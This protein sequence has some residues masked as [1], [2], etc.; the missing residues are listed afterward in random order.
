MSLAVPSK[1]ALPGP[2]RRPKDL[3]ADMLRN[4]QRNT[5]FVGLGLVRLTKILIAAALA[6][7]FA[8]RAFAQGCALCYT[9]AAAA[10]AAAARSLD[11]GILVLLI[12]ALALFISVIVFAVRRA[13]AADSLA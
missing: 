4:V 13:S 10:G 5:G 7:A 8:P 6:L 2:P 12:P 9:T 11:L 3:T 1:A